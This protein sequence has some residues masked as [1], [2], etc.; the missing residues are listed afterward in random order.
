MT[1]DPKKKKKKPHPTPHF[2]KLII[3]YQS[4]YDHHF[5]LLLLYIFSNLNVTYNRKYMSYKHMG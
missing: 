4:G 5:S 1:L 3:T 2:S